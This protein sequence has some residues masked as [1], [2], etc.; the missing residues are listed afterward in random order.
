[1]KKYWVNIGMVAMVVVT[2]MTLSHGET[3]YHNGL[4]AVVIDAI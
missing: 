3:I 4:E 1:M 2:T